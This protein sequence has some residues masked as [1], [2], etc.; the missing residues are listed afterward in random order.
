[1]QCSKV[2]TLEYSDN[3]GSDMDGSYYYN[4]ELV[5]DTVLIKIH[6]FCLY[7]ILE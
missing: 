4:S 6:R 5:N 7:I 1:M 3:S 2:C